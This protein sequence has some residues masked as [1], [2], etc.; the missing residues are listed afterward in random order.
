[1]PPTPKQLLQAV[2][3]SRNELQSARP[4]GTLRAAASAADLTI[5]RT[6][7]E[8]CYGNDVGI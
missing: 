7:E 4:Q 8:V 3:F 6:W 1:M 2:D 5:K